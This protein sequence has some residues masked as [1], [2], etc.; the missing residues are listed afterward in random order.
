MNNS[1]ER[2]KTNAVLYAAMLLAMVTWGASWPIGKIIA[3]S[4]QPE[5]M[6]FWRFSI[7]FIACF[8][9]MLVLKKSFRINGKSARMIIPGAI[10][11]ISYNKFYFWGLEYGLAG[12]GG[13]LVTTLNPI[14]T[15]VLTIIIF[16]KRVSIRELGGIILGLT[17]GMVIMQIWLVNL[18]SLIK[19]G[20]LFFVCASGSWAAVSIISD[21]SKS[22]ISPIVFSFY[23]FGTAA[24]I[25]FFLA[26]RYDMMKVFTFGADFWFSLLFLAFM[27]T[28][29]ATVIYFVAATRL[30]S[31]KASSF[32]FLV[33][34]SALVTSWMLLGEMPG[35]YTLFGGITAVTAVYLITFSKKRT[36]INHSEN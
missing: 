26:I 2:L 18:D 19:S 5:V 34:A 12:S 8:P 22:S 20:N 9:V 4:I 29:F 7:A 35:I 10:F 16:R 14:F 13:V 24:F 36:D 3:G 31:R 33:P 17:G 15:F 23:T 27:A 6:I 25:D 28:T 21:K 11:L 32:I 30:G 1:T